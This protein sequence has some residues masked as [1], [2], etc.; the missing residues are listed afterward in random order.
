MNRTERLYRIDQLIHQRDV[1][2]RQELLHELEISWATL[3]R[4][5]AYLR[6][7]LN[8][9]IV[10]DH[11]RGGYAFD[12]SGAG[13]QY[14]LPGLWFNAQEIHALLTMHRLLEELD[15]GGL[16]GPQIAPLM[17]RLHGM[18]DSSSGS[19]E[20]VM[21]RVRVIP[22]Q[23]R[24]VDA[25][26]FEV[27]GSALVQR[28]RLDIAYYTRGRNERGRREL[29]PQRLVHYRNT[30]YLDAWCHRTDSLRVFAL[31]AIEDAR[32]IDRKARSVSQAELDRELGAGYGIYRGKALRWAVLRFSPE[33]ARWVSAEVWHPKQET[34]VLEDGRYELKLP[35]AGTPELEM[36]I[37]R[38]G[39][40][41]EVVSP[42][43]LRRR[44]AARH[45]AAAARY[46]G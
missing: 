31:D 22:A 24:P 38:H 29:S 41:V 45:A 36:D 35:Y 17:A 28:H 19:A 37:L 39:E 33:A 34:R 13:P 5:M 43:A 18:L 16:L 44:I 40:Q 21:K 27:V 6:D 15:T 2:T 11:D 3:K 8:A 23:N 4:D 7:R 42:E 14:E 10:F 1:V 30:W 12:R 26:W 25:K 20:E 32:M 46:G 9:P